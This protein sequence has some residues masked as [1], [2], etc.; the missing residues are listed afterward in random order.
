MKKFDMSK[1]DWK[2]VLTIG[3]MVGAAIIG[4]VGEYKEKQEIEDLK[5]T[6]KALKSKSEGS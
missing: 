3:T 1:I 4:A 2:Q 6:V 5:E